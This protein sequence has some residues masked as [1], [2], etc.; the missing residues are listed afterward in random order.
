MGKFCDPTSESPTQGSHSNIHTYCHTIYPIH[1]F[2]MPVGGAIGGQARC[3]GRN[4]MESNLDSICLM[5]SVP[6]HYSI[7]TITM[8]PSSYS[9]SHRPPLMALFWVFRTHFQYIA[10]FWVISLGRY[11]NWTPLL[12]FHW[13]N[14][15][16]KPPGGATIFC[17]AQSYFLT[18]FIA[19]KAVVFQ[20]SQVRETS[21][22]ITMLSLIPK[23]T[24][25]ISWSHK[26]VSTE[27]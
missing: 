10:S 14:L 15:T 21:T 13:C 1:G 11:W 25:K 4:R 6:F 8:S 24:S 18:V 12:L 7:P 5:C 2:P 20:S 22:K 9:S 17:E 23:R 19:D 26:K 27:E 3:N 16:S